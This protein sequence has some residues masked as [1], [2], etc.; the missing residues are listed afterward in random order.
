MPGCLDTTDTLVGHAHAAQR[1]HTEALVSNCSLCTVAALAETVPSSIR[2]NADRDRPNTRK[3][4]QLIPKL[5]GCNRQ[6]MNKSRRDT[7]AKRQALCQVIV[8]RT[9]N[10]RRTVRL[11]H[12]PSLG[13]NRAAQSQLVAFFRGSPERGAYCTPGKSL[14]AASVDQSCRNSECYGAHTCGRSCASTTSLQRH[15][16]FYECHLA[17]TVAY[18]GAWVCVRD[19]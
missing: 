1:L 14:R 3:P 13:L 7:T 9:F 10:L 5:H 15:T 2:T 8:A 11:S 16:D 19:S 18:H 4:Q 17:L 6:H 12:D